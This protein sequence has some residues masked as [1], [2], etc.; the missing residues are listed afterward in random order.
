MTTIITIVVSLCIF[1][2]ARELVCWYFKINEKL[3]VLKNIDKNMEKM[4]KTMDRQ[5]VVKQKILARQIKAVTA[6]KTAA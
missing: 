3:E 5:A 2:L 1:M 6:D 4:A